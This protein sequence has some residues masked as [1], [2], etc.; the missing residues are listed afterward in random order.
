MLIT[1]SASLAAAADCER[2]TSTA[3]LEAALLEARRS[4]ERLDTTAFVAATDQVDAVVPCL[5]EPITRHLSAEVHRT[6]GIRAVTERSPDAA[7]YFA[8]ARTIEPAYKFPSTL[9]PE[10]NPVRTEYGTFDLASG[11]FEPLPPPREGTLTL[12]A[13]TKLY[14]PTGWPTLA[15]YMGP[16]GAIGWTTYLMPGTP[17]PAYPTA[18]GAVVPAPLLVEPV[19]VVPVTPPHRNAK[20]PLAVASLTAGILTGTLYGL[21]GYNEGRFKDPQTPD[22]D[23][24]GF[25]ATAN[26]L[27]VVSAFTGAATLGFGVAAIAVK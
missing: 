18:D 23:L 20:L 12:D 6:K 16:D 26:S 19:P 24:D 3:D 13:A 9:I 22:A 27:V 1:L 4:L 15:Q 21:A 8:A 5:G 7:R 11:G 2:A 10:G 17:F 14:R 25:R